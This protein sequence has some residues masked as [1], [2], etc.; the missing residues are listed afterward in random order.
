MSAR[1][2]GRCRP[3]STMARGSSRSH[4]QAARAAITAE[5]GRIGVGQSDSRLQPASR[6]E[7]P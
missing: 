7:I 1:Q 5:I 2:D 3:I 6:V 4:C